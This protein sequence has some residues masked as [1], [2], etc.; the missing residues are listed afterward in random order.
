M[1]ATGRYYRIN[2]TV[3]VCC[4]I[5]LF[6]MQYQPESAVNDWMNIPYDSTPENAFL[7]YPDDSLRFSPVENY[8]GNS[9]IAVLAAEGE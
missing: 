4:V 9:Y 3:E 1:P 5:V 2:F 6:G 8:H 7:L